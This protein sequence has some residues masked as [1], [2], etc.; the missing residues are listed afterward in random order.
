MMYAICHFQ[1][2]QELDVVNSE[3]R[4][5]SFKWR[6]NVTTY[7][8]MQIS[9]FTWN[10]QCAMHAWSGSK[11]ED[12]ILC[13]NQ[14]IVFQIGIYSVNTKNISINQKHWTALHYVGYVCT[15][16]LLT[17]YT[18]SPFQWQNTKHRGLSYWTCLVT[19]TSEQEDWKQC[20]KGTN[21]CQSKHT[22]FLSFDC[23]LKF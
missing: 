18:L 17:V 13:I 20:P 3:L 4:I 14:H 7:C 23:S 15:I 19:F 2:V 5:L 8:R 16:L 22:F 21:N 1:L 9:I 6:N 12:E 10:N 11:V